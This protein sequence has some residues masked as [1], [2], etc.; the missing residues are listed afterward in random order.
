MQIIVVLEKKVFEIRL[1]KLAFC[2]ERC[3]G[4]GLRRMYESVVA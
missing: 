1:I 3:S 4:Q 2:K